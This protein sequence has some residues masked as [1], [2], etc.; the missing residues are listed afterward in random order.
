MILVCGES[1]F[2]VFLKPNKIEN[3]EHA[4]VHLN[5]AAGGSPFNVAVGLARLGCKVALSTDIGD[6]ALGKEIRNLIIKENI[7]IGLVR[8][9]VQSTPLALIDIDQ[10]GSASYRFSGLK[11]VQLHPDESSLS[12]LPEPVSTIHI[13]SY[14]LVSPQSANLLFDFVDRYSDHVFVSLDPNIRLQVEPDIDLWRQSIERF[15]TKAHLIKA[16]SED[17]LA[18]YGEDADID[19]IARRW[20]SNCCQLV[21]LTKGEEGASFFT[22][23]KGRVDV[24]TRSVVVVDTVGAGDSFQAAMLGWLEN[25]GVATADDL[26]NLS[27]AALFDLANFAIHIASMVCERKGPDFPRL[28]ELPDEVAVAFM[29]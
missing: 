24:T 27:Q 21:V 12:T 11:Y 29:Q 14:A 2:D 13:G 22:R 20:L 16:S 9:T 17:L 28:T 19:S 18:L 25:N 8:Q 4:G 26:A 15:R 23:N 7:D 1:L 10:Q 3:G 5:A 6:D